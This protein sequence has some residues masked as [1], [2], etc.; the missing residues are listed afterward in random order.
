MICDII[1]CL[2][3]LYQNKKEKEIQ[4]KI[5]KREK[6][7]R[8]KPSP[9]FTTLTM[10]L[11]LF[12]VNYG[13]ELRIGFEIRKKKKHIKVEKFVKKVKEIYEKAKIVLKKS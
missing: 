5:K 3:H 1:I 4:N 8:I 11:L 9:L 2:F 12:K 13:Q 7:N 10:K 6:K